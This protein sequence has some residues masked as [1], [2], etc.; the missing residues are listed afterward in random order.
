MTDVSKPEDKNVKILNWLD[1]DYA[2]EV[3]EGVKFDPEKQY[4][5]ELTEIRREKE[6]KDDKEQNRLVLMWTEQDSNVVIRQ[7]HFLNPK[8][9]MN[10]DEPQRSGSLVKLAER[11]GYTVK[12]GD[13]AFHPKNFL[14]QGMKITAHI[15]DQIN[16]KTK[17][18]TGFSEIDISTVKIAGAKA[19][20]SIQSNPED[21]AKW[22]QQVAEGKFATQEKFVQNLASTGRLTEVAP[23]MDAAKQ[24]LI[25]FVA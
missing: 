20:Q 13:K 5:L 4:T 21:V 15:V 11:L 12:I 2:M 14:R 1:E 3:T 24:G 6:I 23:F 18:K 16:G 9:T 25:K 17:V 10:K 7:T 8:T 19:Q 22:N